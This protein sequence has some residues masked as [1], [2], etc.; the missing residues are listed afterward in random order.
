MT[1]LFVIVAHAPLA[2]ALKGVAAHTYAECSGDMVAI[3]VPPQADPAEVE[4]RLRDTIG[5][6]EALMKDFDPCF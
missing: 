3:D 6:R 1:P 2:S 4:S 5:T